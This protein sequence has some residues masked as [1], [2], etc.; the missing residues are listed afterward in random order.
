MYFEVLGTVAGGCYANC[1][2]STGAPLLTAND[3]QCFLNKYAAGNTYAN[4]FRLSG[5]GPGETNTIYN[6]SRC[7]NY[8]PC[9]TRSTDN[10]A[11]WRAWASTSLTRPCSPIGPIRP[12]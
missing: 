4:T 10:G 6:F 5:S 11:S 3:F 12:I 1:D 2:G 7:I 8:N 9:L